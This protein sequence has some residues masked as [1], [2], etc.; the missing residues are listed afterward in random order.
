MK[1]SNAS[2]FASSPGKTVRYL[3]EIGL[4]EVSSKSDAGYSIYNDIAVRKIIF[5]RRPRAF[6]LN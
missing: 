4:I 1:I 3:A 6:G 5:A 2:K